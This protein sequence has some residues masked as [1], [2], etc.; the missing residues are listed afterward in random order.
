MDW[1]ESLDRAWQQSEI[2][3]E[4]EGGGGHVSTTVITWGVERQI[5]DG[6]F[7]CRPIPKKSKQV[8]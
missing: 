7:S 1:P 6:K 8:L 4:G 5:N 3:V 2:R